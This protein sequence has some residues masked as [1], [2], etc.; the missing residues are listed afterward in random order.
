MRW[1]LHIGY[2]ANFDQTWEKFRYHVPCYD[3]LKTQR[4][5]TSNWCT[6]GRKIFLSLE[7]PVWTVDRRQGQKCHWGH[8]TSGED[9]VRVTFDLCIQ[10]THRP[11]NLLYRRFTS[12]TALTATN[13]LVPNWLEE[14]WRGWSLPPST[15]SP[16]PTHH[17]QQRFHADFHSAGGVNQGDIPGNISLPVLKFSLL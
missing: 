10:S 8:S 3:T 4:C 15:S 16:W 13:F 11:S 1:L 7:K 14:S 12:Q 5:C 9:S 17:A 6:T 2:S